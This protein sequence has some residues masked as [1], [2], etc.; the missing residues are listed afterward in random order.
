MLTI[1]GTSSPRLTL[2]EQSGSGRIDNADQITD[3]TTPTCVELEK[4]VPM[5]TEGYVQLYG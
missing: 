4:S 3:Q 2:D 1:R 5:I